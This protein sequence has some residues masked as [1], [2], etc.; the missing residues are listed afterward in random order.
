L[1]LKRELENWLRG[2]SRLIILGIG[3]PLRGDDALGV[4]ILRLLENKV[5]R[6]VS[7]IEGGS[8]PENFIG[9]IKSLAPSHILLIDAAHFGGNPGEVN[10]MS[11]EETIGLAISTHTIP[12]YLT[13]ELIKE[14]TDAK[15]LL[16]GIQPKKIDL[17]EEIS[18][19]VKEAIKKVAETIIETLKITSSM[20]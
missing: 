4:E 11:P 7:L 9:K 16:L 18:Y 2:Y 5:P 13:A 3:N 1:N 20:E 8:V 14:A 12:L 19:E 10:F 15:V 6:N 17:G